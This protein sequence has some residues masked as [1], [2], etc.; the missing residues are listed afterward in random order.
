[1][2]MDVQRERRQVEQTCNH[3]YPLIPFNGATAPAPVCMA[4]SSASIYYLRQTFIG[5]R[6]VKTPFDTFGS[7]GNPQSPD[8]LLSVGDEIYLWRLGTAS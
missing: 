3:L 2:G 6:D 5:D 7:R 4:P 8:F 1:M